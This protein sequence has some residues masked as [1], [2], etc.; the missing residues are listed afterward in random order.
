[1][2][3]LSAYVI[4]IKPAPA[5]RA[6]YSDFSF[7][8]NNTVFGISSGYILVDLIVVVAPMCTIASLLRKARQRPELLTIFLCSIAALSLI[9][10]ISMR[11]VSDSP[12]SYLLIPFIICFALASGIEI[13]KYVD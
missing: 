3:S 7:N 12:N 10:S 13:S 2:T 1:M 5:Q 8:F 11:F 9:L 4:F 6:S